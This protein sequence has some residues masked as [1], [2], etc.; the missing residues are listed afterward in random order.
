M[1]EYCGDINFQKRDAK[2][3]LTNKIALVTGARIKIGYYTSLSLLRNGATVI[4]TTRFAIDSVER[5]MQESDYET[6]KSRL[7][8][9]QVS[10]NSFKSIAS[11]AKYV[12]QTFGRLDILINNAAQTI[13]RPRAFYE[14]LIKPKYD[15]DNL[16]K[17]VIDD[18]F[19]FN[20]DKIDLAIEYADIKKFA[21]EK[22]EQ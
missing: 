5:Y 17:I 4:A 18:Y 9:V 16:I 22:E 8:I 19:E 7:S 20:N 13:R 15:P 1:C 14:P 21:E 6:W 12:K 11:L 2:S 10:M 3:V